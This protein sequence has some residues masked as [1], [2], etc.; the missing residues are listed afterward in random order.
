MNNKKWTTENM[1]D[2]LGKTIIVTGGNSGLGYEAVKAFAN[3]GAEVILACRELK[4]G[5]AAKKNI[6]SSKGK[7]HVMKL[8]LQDFKS[9][10][11]FVNEFKAAFTKLDILLNNAGIMTTPY[12]K[13][14]NGLEGQ[15]GTNHFGHFKLTAL[16]LN[17][18]K[19]TP[20]SRV[21]N[22]SSTAHKMGKMNFE[23]LL[24]EK[25]G[26]T[27]LKSYG[28]SKLANLLFT[29]EL[30][31][32]FE[33]NNINSIAVAAH[34][35][36]AQTNLDQFIKSKIWFRALMPIFKFMIQTQEMG[37]LPEIRAAVDPAVKGGQYYGPHK[38]M[39]G[40]PIVEVSTT[41]SYNEADA[42]KLWEISERITGEVMKF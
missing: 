11:S 39:K 19:N 25:G 20:N 32:K 10:E 3:K 5:E 22:V 23:N 21:V 4:K 31:R 41:A 35:G 15:M 37:A 17:F 2:L 12:F 30:Q 6:G 24:F 1:P 34:P 16:L 26:Y 13:T 7:I 8:D 38:G 42:K 36:V 18:I 29:Y 40:F 33:K 14:T 9:I 27:P 28:Q